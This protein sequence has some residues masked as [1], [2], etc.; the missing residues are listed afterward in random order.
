LKEGFKPML[1]NYHRWDII[2]KT[3][4]DNDTR[5]LVKFAMLHGIQGVNCRYSTKSFNRGDMFESI[6]NQVYNKKSNLQFNYETSDLTINNEKFECK[7]ISRHSCASQG[8]IN[9]HNNKHIIGFSSKQ[10]LK[11]VVVDFQDLK[12]DNH[13]HITY[14]NNYQ[15]HNKYVLDL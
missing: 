9:H 12:V 3:N 7:F 13:G 15:V 1:K 6:I 14:Q 10:G 5:N 2:L 11:I 4:T 8:D